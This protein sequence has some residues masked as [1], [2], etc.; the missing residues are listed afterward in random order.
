MITEAPLSSL[1]LMAGAM[2]SKVHSAW[3]QVM[4]CDDDGWDRADVGEIQVGK[5]GEWQS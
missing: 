4:G 1:T 5:G 3:E 2:L